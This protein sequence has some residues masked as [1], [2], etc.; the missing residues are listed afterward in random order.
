MC[1]QDEQ[2]F[3]RTN[4]LIFCVSGKT[5]RF[6]QDDLP[7]KTNKSTTMWPKINSHQMVKCQTTCPSRRFVYSLA[8][9]KAANV[10]HFWQFSKDFWCFSEHSSK[11]VQSLH[12]HE[13]WRTFSENFW[14]LQKITEDFRGRSKYVSMVHQQ[15]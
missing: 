7:I 8:S 4:R 10:K 14:R 13:C 3:R 12:V 2:I 5:H 9:V 15:I 6:F 1:K 11:L